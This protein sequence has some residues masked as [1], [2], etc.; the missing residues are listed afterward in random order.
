MASIPGGTRLDE[1]VAK[2]RDEGRIDGAYST[3]AYLRRDSTQND[4]Y[5]V[6][7]THECRVP[8][9]NVQWVDGKRVIRGRWK[10][11]RRPE[12]HTVLVRFLDAHG[13][14]PSAQALRAIGRT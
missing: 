11:M 1:V 7:V 5:L 2:L 12:L 3:R 4:R 14:P 9:T 8:F 10:E 13:H 6:L